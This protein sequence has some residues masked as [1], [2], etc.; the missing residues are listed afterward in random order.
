MA[1]PN[2]QNSTSRHAVLLAGDFK[3]SVLAEIGTGNLNRIAYSPYGQQ[4][5]QLEVMTRF[6]FNGELCEAK[7][8]WYLLGNGYRAYNPWLMRFHSPDSLSPFDKGGLNA[9]GYC[10]GEPVM[11]S[12]PTGHSVWAFS[13]AVMQLTDEIAAAISPAINKIA[14]TISSGVSQVALSA[15]K[16]V[17]DN[18]LFD[19]DALKKLGPP[20]PKV[21]QRPPA[22]RV[23]YP[24][25]YPVLPS[26]Q[27]G[28]GV[29]PSRPSVNAKNK[30]L[31]SN[32][33]GNTQ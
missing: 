30:N 12:D 11:N 1:Q 23:F 32:I 31:V 29:P 28:L 14:T 25:R 13:R 20:P 4:S 2:Q 33:R 17:A 24:N 16:V 8:E 27:P 6:G 18:I 3:N 7:T 19:P 10:G 5:A 15:K 22:N 26:K 21:I 9:Y